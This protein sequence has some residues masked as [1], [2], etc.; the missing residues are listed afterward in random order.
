VV[1]HPLRGEAGELEFVGAV[2][3]VTASKLSQEALHKAQS[4][5]AH[6]SRV[7]TLGEL[8]ASVAHE[9]SQPLVAIVTNGAASL[10]WLTHTPPEIDEARSG[11]QRMIGDAKR[12]SDV[13]RR[14]RSL[15]RNV[16][17]ERV[18]LDVNNVIDEAVKLVQPEVASHRLSLRLDLAAGL[19]AVRGDRVQL[20]QVIINL[21]INGIQAMAADDDGARELLVRSDR[22]ADH[23]ALVAVQDAGIGIDLDHSGRL[24]DAFFTTKP[25]GMGLGLSICRSIIEAH[26]GR[27]W[28]SRN[29]GPGA[30]F[31]FTLPPDAGGDASA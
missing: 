12:A 27:L 15:S 23:Q 16:G 18:R 26:G 14:I 20:Q 1:A 21:V 29:A 9:V 22:T 3:D 10:R 6:V 4:D 5:L 17:P 2:M 25:N 11:L 28:A 13:I 19:P 30:T 7:M 24:F 8:A 31:Q